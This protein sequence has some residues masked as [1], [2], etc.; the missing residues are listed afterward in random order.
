MDLTVKHFC[1]LSLDELYAIMKMRSDVFVVEQ[2]CVYPDLD[3]RDQNACHF[4]LKEDGKYV[5]YLRLMPKDDTHPY[6]SIGRVLSLERRKGYA[7]CLLKAAI[8]K[9]EELYD[10]K[11][12]YLEAQVY[13]RKLYEKAG[14]QKISEEF[15]EDGIPH[16]KMLRKR[17][18][19]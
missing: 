9:A 17:N 8:Q 16:I 13:A 10:A 19:Q 2:N 6:V 5:S 18:D 7:L 14:F 12:I 11:E 15:L 4:L 1:E 3:N